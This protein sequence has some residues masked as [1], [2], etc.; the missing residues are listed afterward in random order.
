MVS[1]LIADLVLGLELSDTIP[2]FVGCFPEGSVLM[3]AIGLYDGV[4]RVLMGLG[5]WCEGLVLMSAIG[6]YD[7]AE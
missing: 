4:E 6:L 1:F 5:S 7:G 3:P 2:G